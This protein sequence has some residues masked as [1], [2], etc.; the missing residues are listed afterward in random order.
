MPSDV[1]VGGGMILDRE[2][3]IRKCGNCIYCKSIDGS[4]EKAGCEV[5]CKL[6]DR[7]GKDCK[8]FRATHSAASRYLGD[9]I[10]QERMIFPLSET[11]SCDLHNLTHLDTEILGAFCD[12][13]NIHGEELKKVLI[14]GYLRRK[15]SF[16]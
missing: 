3:E 7:D 12:Y 5:L 14:E 11:D 1:C 8:S 10:F 15:S 6:V 16:R 4:N 9:C 13:T 2:D